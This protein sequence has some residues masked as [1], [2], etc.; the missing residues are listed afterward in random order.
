MS[1]DNDGDTSFEPT[2][3]TRKQF[4]KGLKDRSDTG[5]SDHSPRDASDWA[6]RIADRKSA[7][8]GRGE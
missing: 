4:L 7:K 5:A 3:Q 2:A 6:A 8:L 1:R